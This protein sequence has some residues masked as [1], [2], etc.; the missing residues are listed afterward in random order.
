MRIHLFALMALG[1]LSG[2]VM[3]AE[4]R[5]NIVLILADDLGWGDVG[6]N[7]RNEWATP[8]LDGLAA[9]GTTSRG[10][11]AAAVVCARAARRC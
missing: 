4:G 3:A 7:G 6:F 1:G 10:S 5:P 11:T 9:Q 8:N 2:G